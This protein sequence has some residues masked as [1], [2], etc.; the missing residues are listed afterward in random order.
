MRVLIL[1]CGAVGCVLAKMLYKEKSIKSVF[2]G[3]IYFKK[4]KIFGK[5]HYFNINLKNKE[6]LLKFLKSHKLDLIVNAV[7]PV[8]NKDILD[9][10]VKAKVNY[11]DMAACWDP[12]PNKKFK[13]PYKIEQFDFDTKFKENNLFGMIEAGV[14]PG[15]TNLLSKEC[16]EQLE[17][18]ENI[19]IRLLDYS[20]TDEFYFAWSKEALLDE[21]NSKP[22]VYEKGKFRIAEPFS[23]EEE[24]T[25]PPPFNKKKVSLI[26]QDEIGTI[27]FFIKVK[28]IDIKDYNNQVD[29]HKFLY[30]LGLL[31]KKKIMIGNAKISPFEF[32]CNILPEVVLNFGDKK[33]DNAQFAFAVQASGKINGKKK[34]IRYFVSFP[35]QKEINSLK[36]NANF[37]SYPTALSAKL[38]IKSLHKIRNKGIIPPECLEK[39][40]RKTILAEL[41]KIKH[42][43]VKK[44]IWS[45]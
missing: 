18:I 24:Y 10:C 14:S 13:S 23:G 8:F 32:I 30:K 43:V 16:S 29:A 19:K 21:I 36:L 9:A 2:C 3:D 15:L 45:G 42:I 37:I 38:F 31:S 7:S 22:L 26:C 12:H 28:N 27:P 5:T 44:E 4:E 34:T 39:E 6:H 20:G 11:M 33:Y 41:K 17:Q 1:G 40:I 35:K 25:F